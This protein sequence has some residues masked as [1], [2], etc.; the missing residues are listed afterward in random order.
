MLIQTKI[1]SQPGPE[2]ISNCMITPVLQ[3]T[4]TN[5][6]GS[7]VGGAIVKISMFDDVSRLKFLCMYYN[8]EEINNF[9]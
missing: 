2:V 7:N 4:S 8:S 6:G 1:A 5:G 9:E 3:P